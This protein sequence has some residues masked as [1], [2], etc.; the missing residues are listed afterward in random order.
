MLHIF[1][2]I[3]NISKVKMAFQ[4]H[5]TQINAGKC[6]VKLAV[7]RGR[8]FSCAREFRLFIDWRIKRSETISK[9]LRAGSAAAFDR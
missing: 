6:P 8:A 7:G 9:D 2:A 1:V 3:S 5:F 4:L